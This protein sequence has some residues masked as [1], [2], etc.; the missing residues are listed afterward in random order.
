MKPLPALGFVL[1]LVFS[2]ATM[3]EGPNAVPLHDTPQ[4]LPTI[5]FADERG[6]ALTLDR[7]RGKVILLNVWATWCGPCRREMPTLD[8]LQAT[9]GSERFEVVALSIDRAGVGV[10]RRFFDEIG[11]RHLG[12]FIDETMKA[13]RDLRI[14]GLPGTLLIGPDG[15]ELGRLIGP[16][17][18]DT[19]EMVAFFERVIVEHTGK[20]STR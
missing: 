7:W 19:P 8:R 3:T 9:L 6:N 14:F 15:R 1:A 13:S 18:W 4:P 10:V 16:A 11:V 20:E 5:S 17:E 2:T 12:I